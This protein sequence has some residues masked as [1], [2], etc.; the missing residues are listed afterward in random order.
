MLIHRWR[1]QCL[2]AFAGGVLGGMLAGGWPVAMA[3]DDHGDPEGAATPPAAR[4]PARRPSYVNGNR[5]RTARRE[6]ANRTR[7]RRPIAQNEPQTGETNNGLV[8]RR[9]EGTNNNR[10][11]GNERGNRRAGN[12][13]KP[14]N[15]SHRNGDEITL[16]FQDVDIRALINTV[17]EVTGKNFIVDPRVKGKVTLVSGGPLNA[18]QIYEVFLSVLS[19]HNFSAVPAGDVTKIIPSNIVKQQPTPT[20]Y[21]GPQETGDEQITQVYQLEH[22]SVQDLIPILRPLL[23][24]TSHFAAHAPTNTLVFTDTAANVQ[25]LVEI[26]RKVDVPD[27]RSNIHVLYLKYAQAKELATVLTQLTTSIVKPGAQKARLGRVSVQADPAIN[28]LIIN[29]PDNEFSLLKAVVDQLDIERPAGGDVHVVYLRYATATDLVDLLNE[30]VGETAGG[31]GGEGQ[32]PLKPEVSVQADEAT[33]A[34]VVRAGDDDFRTLQAVIEKLDI[35]R[36]QVF[37]ET[38]IAEVGADKAADLGVEWQARDGTSTGEVTA[39]TEFSDFTGGL[40]LGFINELVEDITGNIVPDLSVV[41][42]A[43]R[44]DSNTN[45]LSTPNLLTLDNESA[46]IVVGQEVPF[47]TGQFVSDASSTTI[48]ADG[49]TDGTATGVVNPFQTIERKDVGIKLEITPQINDGDAIRLEIAQEISRVSP[50]VL[51]GASDLITDRRSIKATVQV[52]DGQIV[53]L[54]GL[55]QDDVVDT[56]EWVPVL[57]KIPVLGALFRRKSKSA[58]KRNLMVF[59]RPKIIRTAHDIAGYTRDRYGYMQRQ[60]R[61]G[62]PDTERLIH[63]V[64]PPVLPEVEWPTAE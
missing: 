41:L 30:V 64:Q 20:I 25:R 54:G 62:Q 32:V 44:S 5:S 52:D 1:N 35:R 9:G 3:Q 46:E 50:V 55:I 57:G 45:I 16:N 17:S 40:T 56:V 10:G 61:F 22:G 37:V 33:N 53:V 48:V 34:L 43:L 29:A 12:N 13:Q 31:G 27:R 42:R 28:A 19:V 36:E 51:Q 21:A 4:S 26:I 38:I 8:P 24:P 58:T 7:M 23:P 39:N 15:G 47:V 49:G 63:G 2:V 60:E 59:L 18:E 14:V 6:L 11:T